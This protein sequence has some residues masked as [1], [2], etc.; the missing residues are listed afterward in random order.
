MN[1]VNVMLKIVLSLTLVAALISPVQAQQAGDAE[2]LIKKRITDLQ[3]YW[4]ASDL[5]GV[6][7]LYQPRQSPV[8]ALSYSEW[9][10]DIKAQ[11]DARTRLA[12]IFY[13]FFPYDCTVDGHHCM[14]ARVQR[15]VNNK[16]VGVGYKAYEWQQLGGDWYIVR[17][18][19]EVRGE[20]QP[21]PKQ[22]SVDNAEPKAVQPPSPE[23]KQP[24]QAVT[25]VVKV[26]VAEVVIVPPVTGEV[27]GGTTTDP[28]TGQACD[29]L[30]DGVDYVYGVQLGVFGALASAI[31]VA[32]AA[33]GGSKIYQRASGNYVVF[34]G[35]FAGSN[36]A[37]VWLQ[38]L[39]RNYDIDVGSF[40]AKI[41]R[42]D[43]QRPICN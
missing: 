17:E 27:T 2:N 15:L 31:K 26:P 14:R 1:I 18:S 39:R 25:E 24:Q 21:K 9:K 37:K 29:L 42:T 33:G 22:V 3:G 32:A 30:G 34:S 4:Q 36:E 28:V 19:G 41:Q 6:L 40:V 8:A 10:A 12:F 5:A 13:D 38:T 43:I 7:S 35:G 23:Q 11:L 16:V 20:V